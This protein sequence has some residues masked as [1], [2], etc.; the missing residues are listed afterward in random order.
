MDLE[1]V[2]VNTYTAVTFTPV[3][4]NKQSTLGTSRPSY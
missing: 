4:K 3:L 1:D 2:Q